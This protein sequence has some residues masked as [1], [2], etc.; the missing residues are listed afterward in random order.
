MVSIKILT[1]FTITTFDNF[2]TVALG[3]F[4]NHQ[5][6]TQHLRHIFKRLNFI[7]RFPIFRLIGSVSCK[8]RNHFTRKLEQFSLFFSPPQYFD[9]LI[10]RT[11]NSKKKY[12]LCLTMSAEDYNFRNN[13][14]DLPLNYKVFSKIS[15]SDFTIFSFINS[16]LPLPPSKY[17]KYVFFSTNF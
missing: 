1:N 3:A 6:T 17:Y 4:F 2:S 16:N 5:N 13:K 10:Q 14:N 7:L 15:W 12:Q 8:N 11:C 9:V